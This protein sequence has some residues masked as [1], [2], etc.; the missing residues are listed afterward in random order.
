MNEKTFYVLRVDGVILDSLFQWEEAD[1]HFVE[2][3]KAGEEF[4]DLEVY[5]PEDVDYFTPCLPGV[6]EADGYVLSE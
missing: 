1:Q 2:C 5:E 6:G 4:R 3:L